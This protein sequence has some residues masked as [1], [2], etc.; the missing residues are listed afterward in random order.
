VA[1]RIRIQ[2]VARQG[3]VAGNA[4][5]IETIVPLIT[6][7]RTNLTATTTGGTQ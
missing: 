7:T 5:P 4:Q 1:V 6:Q 2:L 3:G